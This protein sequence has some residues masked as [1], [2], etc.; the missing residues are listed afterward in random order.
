MCYQ[1]GL[2]LWLCSGLE[3]PRRSLSCVWGLDADLAAVC[4]TVPQ[5]AF[6]VR[7]PGPAVWWL[8]AAV[9]EEAERKAVKSQ[10]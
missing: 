9:V 8:R 10:R 7:K 4:T 1:P 2:F 6:P 5:M 3:G